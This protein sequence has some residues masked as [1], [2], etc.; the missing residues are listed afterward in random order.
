MVAGRRHRRNDGSVL[1]MRRRHR[2]GLLLLGLLGISSVARAHLMPAQRG[3]LNVLGDAVFAALSLPVSALAGIDDN[4]DGRLSEPELTA[5]MAALQAMLSRRVQFHNGNETGRLDLVMPMPEE[6]ERDPRSVAG[7]THVL[8]LM[9]ATFRGPP[10]ALRFSL[11]VFGTSAS[12]RQFAV[13]TT[14]GPVVDAAVLTPAQPTYQF[15]R[16][17]WRVAA[18]FG[19]LGIRHILGGA[20]HLLFL[21]TILVAASGWRAWLGALSSFTVAHSLTLLLTLTGV[22]RVAPSVV[23][24]LIAAS[25]VVMAATTLRRGTAA[26]RPARLI[27]V[28]F[29]CGLL[30]GL[31]FAAAVGDLGVRGANRVASLVGFNLGIEAGQLLFVAALVTLNAGRPWDAPVRFPRAISWAALVLATVWLVQRVVPL[32]GR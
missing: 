3:T 21:L 11:D 18:D 28:V 17:P 30:H 5:H 23:E 2:A 7:G 8:V 6:D 9:K 22:V 25:V 10:T 16:A 1:R 14:R 4:H 31:G 19:A 13:T 29:A 27:A 12:E 32:L 15:F 26:A 20:D 24:P